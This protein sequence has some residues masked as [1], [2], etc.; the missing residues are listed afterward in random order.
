MIFFLAG[1]NA[2]SAS[3]AFMAHELTVNPYI[4]QRL[5]EEIRS[6]HEK[7]AGRPLTSEVL[8]QMKYLDMVVSETLRMWPVSPAMERFVNKPYVIEH[9]NGSRLR[10]EVGDGVWI[11]T[12]AIHRDPKYFPIPDTFDPERFSDANKHNIQ[13]G[14][15]MPFGIGPRNCIGSRFALM[16]MKS[17]FVYLLLD[18]SLERCEKTVDPLVLQPGT[19]VT[20][21][22][23]NGFYATLRPREKCVK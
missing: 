6:V 7:L 19:T 12:L 9:P 11:P 5:Y 23:A 18:F 1:F 8:H 15:Y 13:P 4:Q 21:D 16:E 3:T 2:G 20:L 14:T 10:L 17:V 22:A